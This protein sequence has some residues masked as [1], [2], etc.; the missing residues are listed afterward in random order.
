M[1]GEEIDVCPECNRGGISVSHT[2]DIPKYRCKKCGARFDQP[3][4]RP[5]QSHGQ[6]TS[7]GAQ[8]LIDADPDDIVTD[9]GVPSTHIEEHE[10]TKTTFTCESCGDRYVFT[11][12]GDWPVY[13]PTCG[14]N[15]SAADGATTNTDEF[16]EAAAR[17]TQQPVEENVGSH[18]VDAAEEWDGVGARMAETLSEHGYQTVVDLADAEQAAL[19]DIKH[20][21]PTRAE[22]MIEQASEM[23]EADSQ[24]ADTA[25]GETQ[26]IETDGSGGT[27]TEAVDVDV[28]TRRKPQHPDAVVAKYLPDDTTRR[29][30]RN[31]AEEQRYLGDVADALGIET[32]AARTLLHRLDCYQNVREGANYRG[33]AD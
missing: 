7:P 30:V 27:E 9:G 16:V 25:A 32:A 17:T 21:G 2:E 24:T 5:S 10:V 8:A 15:H 1:Y 23:L 3:N 33:G 6:P 26:P 12:L 4:R 29:E 19:E 18:V 11:E 28:S 13:C 31:L 22:A 14:H 20:V